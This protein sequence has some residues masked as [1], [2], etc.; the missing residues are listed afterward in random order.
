[1]HN[2]LEK[3]DKEEAVRK[4]RERKEKETPICPPTCTGKSKL[5][6]YLHIAMIQKNIISYQSLQM[7]NWK[8]WLETGN[9]HK[10]QA[11]KPLAARSVAN[12]WKDTRED[13][14]LASLMMTEALLHH[15]LAAM[16]GSWNYS[17]WS[18]LVSMKK[19]LVS[20]V[21]AAKYM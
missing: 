9:Q 13:N 20:P 17:I 16:T 11:E 18:T 12:Q 1:M 6:H 4:Y 10:Q 14:V 21:M 2:M 3:E 5:R 8:H 7:Q 15:V 19:N